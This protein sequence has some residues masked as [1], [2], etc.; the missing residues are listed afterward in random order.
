MTCQASGRLE[1]QPFTMALSLGFP[2]GL[3]ITSR[4]KFRG[5]CQDFILL[6][7]MPRIKP[8]AS[9]VLGKLSTPQLNPQLP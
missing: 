5:T 1:T 3:S 7:S 6:I 2:T 4:S 8:R 9:C